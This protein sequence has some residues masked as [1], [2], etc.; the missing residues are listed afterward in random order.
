MAGEEEWQIVSIAEMRPQN[1]HIQFWA[2]FVVHCWNK[3]NE[4]GPTRALAHT[5][6]FH[7]Q[8]RWWHAMIA[9]ET[10]LLWWCRMEEALKRLLV[11][12]SVANVDRSKCGA[13][14]CARIAKLVWTSTSE[15]YRMSWECDVSVLCAIKSNLHTSLANVTV[16]RCKLT[17]TS[18]R[19][20]LNNTNRYAWTIE[21][22]CH[23]QLEWFSKIY[24][25]LKLDLL[26]LLI[27]QFDDSRILDFDCWICMNI[28]P[29]SHLNSCEWKILSAVIVIFSHSS[30]S[31]SL[32]LFQSLQCKGDWRKRFNCHS[33]GEWVTSKIIIK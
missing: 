9:I 13:V 21:R 23:C 18:R 2:V 16:N 24:N 17:W 8:R 7:K 3:W 19:V 14:V 20:P 11:S 15:C 6:T 12:S 27:S 32:C 1:A 29:T 28:L 33:N 22:P 26:F 10:H 25:R 4:Y 30:P 5:H 31:P